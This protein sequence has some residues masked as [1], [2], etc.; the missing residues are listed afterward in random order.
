VTTS[1]LPL[2]GS[3]WSRASVIDESAFR[4][5]AILRVLSRY[6]GQSVNYVSGIHADGNG[7]QGQNGRLRASVDAA[8][9]GCP[10]AR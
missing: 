6:H 9:L 5:L 7:G 8:L 3:L 2:P 4:K 10:S 1:V